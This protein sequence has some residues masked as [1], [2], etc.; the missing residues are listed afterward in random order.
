MS[1]RKLFI[2]GNWKMNKTA[3]QAKET[4]SELVAKVSDVKDKVDIAVCVPYTAL[5]SSSQVLKD[6]SVKLGAQDISSFA[7]GAYTGEISAEMLLDLNVKYVIVGHSERRQYHAESDE[8]VSI[9]SKV[10]LDSGLLPIVCIGETLEERE[11]GRT[12]EVVS[13]QL[14]GSLVGLTAD[15]ML[16]VTIAYEPVW[17][18]GT[19]KT[20]SPEQAQEVHAQI[21]S[22]LVEAYGSEVAEKVRLQYGGSVKPGNSNELMAQK[23]IDGALVGGA[24]LEASMFAE[25]IANAL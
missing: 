15:E 12:T 3:S 6:G 2:A 25:L 4:L 22:L 23:D 7:S 10:A 11:S 17:A 24:S 20:A 21:R 1:D 18:I 5:E 19:G 8:Q 13:G 14:K 9:K 16:K